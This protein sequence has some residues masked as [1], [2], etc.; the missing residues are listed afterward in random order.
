MPSPLLIAL[1]L[2]VPALSGGCAVPGPELVVE[3]AVSAAR[4]GDR[5]ALLECFTPRSR[6]ILETWWRAADENNPALATL[7]ARD[8][9]VVS[10]RLIPSRDFEPERAIIGIEEGFDATRLVAHRMGGMWRLDVLDSQ[11]ADIGSVGDR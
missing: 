2:A 6:A 3:Q 8:V 9:R 11:R 4:D 10:V 1:A 5:E 7:G